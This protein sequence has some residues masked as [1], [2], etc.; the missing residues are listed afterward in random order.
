[1]YKDITNANEWGTKMIVNAETAAN[2]RARA[3]ALCAFL[4]TRTFYK[5]EEV[6]HLNPPTNEELSALEVFELNRDKPE[7]FTAYVT[8]RT[9]AVEAKEVTTW[10]GQRVAVRCDAGPW[11]TNNMG[12]KWR[13]LRIKPDFCRWYYT[14]REY[15][16]RQCVNFKR[17]KAAF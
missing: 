10:T 11:H 6:A 4:G 14:G 17:M 7:Q 2:I 15:D 16:S 5:A 9:D 3:D 1:M 12:A 13:Q 8:W